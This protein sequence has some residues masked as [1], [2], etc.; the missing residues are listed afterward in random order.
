MRKPN[1]NYSDISIPKNLNLEKKIRIHPDC[2]LS[3]HKNLVRSFLIVI[4]LKLV[5]FKK[6]DA[7]VEIFRKNK[8]K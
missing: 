4:F 6:H 3:Y 2:L 1:H 7:S 5:S 8:T